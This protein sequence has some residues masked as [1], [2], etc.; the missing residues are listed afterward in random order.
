MEAKAIK[1]LEY[2]DVDAID[3]HLENVEYIIMAAPSPERFIQTPIHFTIFLN[4]TQ[5][6]SQEIQEAI[7]GKFLIENGIK[8]PQEIM[9]QLMPVG[10]ST[11]VHETH[12]PL[13]LI[14]HED[15]NSIPHKTMFVMDFLADSENFSET[16]EKSLTGWSY[17]YN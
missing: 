15:V 5:N 3:K 10:F 16:K 17:S 6:F 1:S 11:G 9:S 2:L 7:F 14:K 13:L 12:M 8:N 4:T